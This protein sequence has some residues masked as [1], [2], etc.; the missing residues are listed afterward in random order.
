MPKFTERLQNAWNAFLSR[1]PTRYYDYGSTSGYRYDRVR[2]SINSQRTIV[3]AIYNRIALD[4]AMIDMHH[5]QCGEDGHFKEVIKSPLDYCLSESANLDQ[6][7]RS[8]IL[9]IVMSM[10]DEGYVAV[11]PTDCSANPYTTSTYDIEKLRTGRI[12]NWYPDR[13][14]VDV[15]N[16]TNG[17]RE[18]IV[19]PKSHI[20]IIENPLYSVMNEPNSI[21]QRLI[22]KLSLLDYVD[23]QSSSGKLD[24]IIQLP[25]VIKTEARRQQAEVRRKDI[26]TQLSGSKYGIAY[27]DG[28]EK[29]T[30]I[31][32][33]LEN[34]LWAQ[35]KDLTAMLYNQLGLT[36]SIF[37]GTAK[38][39]EKIDYYNRTIDPIHSFIVEELQRKFISANARTR[40]QAI[41]YFRNPFRLI[42]VSSLAEIA[43]KFTRNE[44][45][46]SNEIRTQIGYKPSDN[47]AANELRNSNLNRSDNERPAIVPDIPKPKEIN[48]NEV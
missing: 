16:E 35:V 38:E 31:N 10:F 34:N 37:N 45:L 43:D 23:E 2:L 48:Q 13:V 36:E 29:I 41:Q 20:A 4:C 14:R 30:Q 11:V 18:Q 8:L 44:I 46:S 33:P 42:P 1:E 28:T 21:L 47:P 24:L 39:E 6:T 25:Y 19:L 9:D 12:V 5:V 22:R 3:A 17:R 15:Y 7:G 27:T 32:R 40:G 26:E